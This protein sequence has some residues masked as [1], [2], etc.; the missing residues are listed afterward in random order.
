MYLLHIGKR[1]LIALKGATIFTNTWRYKIVIHSDTIK[2][3]VDCNIGF[4][5][6]IGVKTKSCLG[7]H[8][9]HWDI[10]A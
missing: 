4:E 7:H 8:S 10:F 2:S 3:Q 9:G 1:I 6:I 5:S